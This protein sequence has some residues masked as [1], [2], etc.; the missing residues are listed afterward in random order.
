MA[1]IIISLNDARNQELKFYFTGVPCKHGHIATR[2]VKKSYCT[3]CAKARLGRAPTYEIWYDMIRRCVNPKLKAYPN[4][5][6]RGIKVCDRW[7]K[8]ENFLEDM[9]QRPS[10]KY[11]IDRINNNGNYEP[12]NCRWTTN[13]VQALNKRGVRVTSNGVAY[14][15]NINRF[16]ARCLHDGKRTYLGCFKTEQEAV[17]ANKEFIGKKQET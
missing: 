13:E 15:K 7:T 16:I 17:A 6:G 14:N 10:N 11:S 4:Y 1:D 3:S 12:S 9:G 5:G 2:T 8:Y